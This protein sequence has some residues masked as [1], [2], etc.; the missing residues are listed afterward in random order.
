MLELIDN[1]FYI[2][3]RPSD[4]KAMFPAKKYH[5]WAEVFVNEGVHPTKLPEKII[6]FI[7]DKIMF[8]TY[9]DIVLAIMRCLVRLNKLKKFKIIYVKTP[10]E[11]IEIELNEYG[12]IVGKWP[13]EEHASI[14]DAY[15][16]YSFISKGEE[17]NELLEKN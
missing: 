16:H 14:V 1:E 15:F 11:K 10:E 6:W 5:P 4:F 13:E 12:D 7:K 9:S 17:F 2:F 3:A 8:T